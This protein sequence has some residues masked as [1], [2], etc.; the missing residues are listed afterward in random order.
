MF[1]DQLKLVH[2]VDT[3]SDVLLWR[4][5]GERNAK[6]V[7]GGVDFET[8]MPCWKLVARLRAWA[9][10]LERWEKLDR[11]E[12]DWDA[13]ARQLMPYESKLSFGAYIASCL[14]KGR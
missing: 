11:P 8:M 4:F 7:S 2:R 5:V 6:T 1:L 14:L 3:F 9:D 13:A 12:V 10:D